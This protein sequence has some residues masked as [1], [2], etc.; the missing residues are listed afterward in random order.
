M[1][2][3]SMQDILSVVALSVLLFD[4]MAASIL[5]QRGQARLAKIIMASGIVASVALLAIAYI[6]F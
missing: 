5:K 6:L 4:V 1:N 3:L 2:E